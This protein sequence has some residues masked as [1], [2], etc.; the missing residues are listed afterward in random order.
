MLFLLDMVDS[1]VRGDDEDKATG[2]PPCNREIV[3]VCP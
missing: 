1:G 2:V 3:K